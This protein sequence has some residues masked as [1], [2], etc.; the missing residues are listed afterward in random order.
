LRREDVVVATKVTGPSGQMPWIRGGPERLDAEAII[1]AC[2]GSLARLGLDHVDILQLHWPDRY[3][4]MFGESL[5]RPGSRYEDRVPLEEQMEALGS[6][7]RQGKV[8]RV[9]LSNETP[10][11][12]TRCCDLSRYGGFPRIH[13]LQNS[14]S[15]LC[16]TFDCGGLAECCWEEGVELLAY[17]PLAMGLLTGK[18]LPPEGEGADLGGW[19][20]P[21]ARLN[22]YKGRY[23]EAES[24]YERTREVTR[25]VAR[26]GDLAGRHGMTLTELAVRFVLSN[27]R[28]GCAVLGATS[29]SQLDEL[30]DYA[31]RGALDS[32]ILDEIDGVHRAAPNPTP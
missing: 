21:G 10:W 12:L 2:E 24:R 30:L 26:Y 15:L 31:G 20:P 29:C 16:R 22:L 17:S 4:P 32:R 13:Y 5:Y 19:G 3:V 27:E 23:S 14:Y 25:A 6:L 7:V 9:G 8:R 1:E 28:V 11:G 18:Y